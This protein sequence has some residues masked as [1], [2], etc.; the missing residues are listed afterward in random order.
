M[1]RLIHFF[2]FISLL[3]SGVAF[4]KNILFSSSKNVQLSKTVSANL[5]ITIYGKDWKDSIHGILTIKSGKSV[6]YTTSFTNLFPE[7]KYYYD[8]QPPPDCKNYDSC[9]IDFYKHLVEDITVLSSSDRYIRD[10]SYYSLY[11]Q[12]ITPQLAKIDS[13]K[14]ASANYD[15]LFFNYLRTEDYV[16][17]FI[18]ASYYKDQ[19]ILVYFPVLNKLF[20][21]DIE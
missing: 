21:V 11:H 6:L 5:Q 9:K 16:Q 7:E 8:V 1:T 15:S 13:I 19:A 14:S 17:F 4:P 3:L 18:P 10:T 20:D 12:V 2:L